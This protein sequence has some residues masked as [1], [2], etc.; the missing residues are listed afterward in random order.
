MKISEILE[1]SYEQ[2]NKLSTRELLAL[3]NQLN[4]AVNKRIRRLAESDE[5]IYSPAV[6]GLMEQ[7]GI[8]DTGE[9]PR[10]STEGISGSG[11]QA[12]NQAL[13]AFRQARDFLMNKTSSVRGWQKYR[14]ETRKRIGDAYKRSVVTL[15]QERTFWKAYNRYMTELHND[16]IYDSNQVQKWMAKVID[17][18]DRTLDED[19]LLN[20]L[21]NQEK[22][23]DVDDDPFNPRKKRNFEGVK[24]YAVDDVSPFES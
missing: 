9:I 18:A 7:Q 10:L 12:R 3:T 19:D 11:Q 24:F 13:S 21:L 14:N 23:E 8:A 17:E 16:A 6:Q 4:S 22:R 5:G 15:Q 1:M 2:I 20:A